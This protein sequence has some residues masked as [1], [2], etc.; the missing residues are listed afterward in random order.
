[1]SWEA[2][3]RAFGFVAE[4]PIAERP[5]EELGRAYKAAGMEDD[6]EAVRFLI[7]ERFANVDGSDSDEEQRGDGL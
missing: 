3:F 1:V 4:N 2:V 6:A 5:Y 7:G